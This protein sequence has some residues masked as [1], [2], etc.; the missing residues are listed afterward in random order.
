MYL[1]IE[2][3]IAQKEDELARLKTAKRKLETGQKIIIGATILHA[4]KKNPEL[5]RWL[6]DTL[7]N[8]VTRDSDLKRI[9]P[10]L[11]EL[12]IIIGKSK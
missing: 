9:M 11:K 6:L 7:T 2:Q 1:T 8:E 5:A 3:K 4:T 10:V 12:E